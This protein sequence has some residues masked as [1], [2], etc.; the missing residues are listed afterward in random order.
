MTTP[1]HEAAHRALR[2]G[3]RN[4]AELAREAKVCIADAVRALALLEQPHSA[5]VLRPADVA[6]VV[7]R[8]GR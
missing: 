3:I 2:L 6:R 7:G 5:V 8:E 4:P 1:A